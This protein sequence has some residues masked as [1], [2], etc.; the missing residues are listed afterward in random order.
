MG[1]IPP[2]TSAAASATTAR[3]AP[4]ATRPTVSKAPPGVPVKVVPKPPPSVAAPPPPPPPKPGCTAP[5]FE[6]ANAPRATVS[7]TLVSS[8]ATQYW[9]KVWTIDP[10]S[11]LAGQPAP[12]ITIPTD[13]M[14]AI[15]WQ[16]SGWQ[17]AILACDGG[18]GTMQVMPGTATWMNAR[19]RTSYDVHTLAG[20]VAL[21]TEYLQWLVM[22]FGLYDFAGNFDLT[23]TLVTNSGY[24]L[25]DAV[26]SAYNVGYGSVERSD[27]TIAIP[28]PQYVRNVEALMTGC[29]CL[30]Y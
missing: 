7:S 29:E 22:Y 23:N 4:A 27:G 6:G 17:S 10:P 13:L 12:A 26:I 5:T 9:L 20:N 3:P 2:P 1:A 15:A 19:Y 21:G 28:N 18:I 16:E 8:G 14:K 24:S 25:L 11:A 30:A